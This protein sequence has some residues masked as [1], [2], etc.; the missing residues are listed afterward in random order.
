MRT[1]ISPVYLRLLTVPVD[2]LVVAF[3]TL[4][5]SQLTIRPDLFLTLYDTEFHLFLVLSAF[6]ASVTVRTTLILSLQ[7]Y[8]CTMPTWVN[9]A[10]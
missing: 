9:V 2:F 3:R 1:W 5:R 8:V 10:G 4:I 6:F 7:L